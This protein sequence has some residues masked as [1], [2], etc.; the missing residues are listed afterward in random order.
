VG[1]GVV[2]RVVSRVALIFH[3][4]DTCAPDS[5]T[6]FGEG[7]PTVSAHGGVSVMAALS[8]RNVTATLLQLTR[9]RVNLSKAN[10]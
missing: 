5:L 9:F 4:P 10:V 8:L 7:L 1:R 6:D 3:Q 2:C